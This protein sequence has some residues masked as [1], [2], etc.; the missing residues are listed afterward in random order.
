M[1]DAIVPANEDGEADGG[2][3]PGGVLGG[4]SGPLGGS[5]GG[6]LGGTGGISGLPL[7]AFEDSSF[8]VV[9]GA[10]RMVASEEVSESADALFCRLIWVLI[11]PA[12]TIDE[13]SVAVDAGAW[14]GG[15]V[16][17]LTGV[18]SSSC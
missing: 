14:G 18:C 7:F 16:G 8:E 4:T 11:C 9:D 10:F 2:G 15:G 6:S 12:L 13:L 17:D 5:L 3:V 1:L